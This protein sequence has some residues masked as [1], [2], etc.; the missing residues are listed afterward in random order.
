M[1]LTTI[2]LAISS[3]IDSLGIG[4]TYGIKNTEISFKGKLVIFFISFIIT[5]ISLYFGSI[6]K[7]ILPSY[8]SDYL[9][10][11]I[12]IIIG[13]FICFGALRNDKEIKSN[14]IEN[15][16]D[17]TKMKNNESVKTYSFFI[18]FLGITVKIIKDATS[19]DLD[20]SKKIDSKEAL[21][22]SIVLSIDSICVGIG[23]G[24]I[25]LNNYIFPILIGVFQLFFLSLGTFLGKKIYKF[26]NL[27][28]NIWSII[29]GILL[30]FLGILKLML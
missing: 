11:F 16:L 14:D 21:F 24:I 7:T 23:G 19:S 26:T 4:I 18:K 22:L 30:I 10:S 15:I 1:L 17:T 2:L 13:I 27:P 6:I 9:G 3:S 29:S 8:V 5:L 28:N 25:D 20:N 12:F